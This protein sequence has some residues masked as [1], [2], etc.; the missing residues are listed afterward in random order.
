VN[1]FIRSQLS[2]IDAAIERL[3]G[4]IAELQDLTRHKTEEL[5]RVTRQLWSRGQEVKLMHQNAEQFAE[6]QER[7]Q[8][9]LAERREVRD[10]LAK[11]MK[12]IQALQAEF[13][14]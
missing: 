14:Q 7:Q 5:E 4:R 12:V 2:H 1:P 3:E 6:L 10:R 9:L 13:R 11:V 8:R